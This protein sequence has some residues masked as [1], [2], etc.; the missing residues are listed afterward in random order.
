MNFTKQVQD[1]NIDVL[2]Q[3]IYNSKFHRH[4]RIHLHRLT[5]EKKEEDTW[6]LLPVYLQAIE[7]I[8]DISWA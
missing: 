3:L 4:L 1:L 8:P 6:K 5:L 2:R 7:A